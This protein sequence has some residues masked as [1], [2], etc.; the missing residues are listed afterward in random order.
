MTSLNDVLGPPHRAEPIHDRVL[1]PDQAF[2]LLVDLVLVAHA[3]ERERPGNRL[4]RLDADS[5]ADQTAA[6]SSFSSAGSSKDSIALPF[7]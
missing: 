5:D 3:A 1:E 2:A 4:E 6:S 7:R